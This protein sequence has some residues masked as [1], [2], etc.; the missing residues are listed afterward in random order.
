MS[1]LPFRVRLQIALRELRVPSRAKLVGFVVVSYMNGE[2]RAFPGLDTLEHDMGVGSRHTVIKALRD[3][4]TADF[5]KIVRGQTVNTYYPQ[6]TPELDRLVD[7]FLDRACRRRQLSLDDSRVHQVHPTVHLAHP[8]SALSARE[9]DR[10]IVN[11]I[12]RPSGF[13]HVGDLVMQLRDADEGT[14][15]VFRHHFS[16]L[17]EGAFARALESLERRRLDRTRAPLVSEVRYM[18]ASLKQIADDWRAA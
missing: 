3:L 17:P 18:F 8:P 13:D 15:H 12:G 7:D 10:E 6:L 14:E 16:R 5:L 2:G 11:E 9:V 4:E 1:E